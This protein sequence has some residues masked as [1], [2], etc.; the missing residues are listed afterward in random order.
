MLIADSTLAGLRT[1][2]VMRFKQSYEADLKD[3]LFYTMLAAEIPSTSTSNTYPALDVQPRL[4]QWVGARQLRN[5]KERSYVLTN[6]DYEGSFSISANDV[7]DDNIAAYASSVQHLARS[8]R[9]WPND[10]VVAAMVGG[11]AAVCYDGQF[12][13]DTDH[14]L[15]VQGAAATTQSNRNTGTAL[16]AAN[17]ESVRNAMMIRKAADGEPMGVRPTHLIV[18]QGLEATA[19]RIVKAE[20][21]GY[22]ANNSSTAT[23]SNMN[24]G[25]AE[26]MVIPELDASSAT[27]WYLADLSKGLKPFVFQLRKT[28]NNLVVRNS[29]TDD[30]MFETNTVQ[31]GCHGRGAAGYGFW[32]Y[33]DRCEA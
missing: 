7:A 25:T 18:P 33:I 23:D 12:F 2:L 16:T 22:V 10:L 9:L 30:N 29:P 17:Y 13:F 28:P 24:F 15:E 26:I 11:A 6:V 32:Q 20:N 27:T 4:R 21:V 8:A 14:P 19:K 1:N 3:M 31:V 5:I